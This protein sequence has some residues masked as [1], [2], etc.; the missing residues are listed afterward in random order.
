MVL[1]AT[2][3]IE[4]VLS[5]VEVVLTPTDKLST[6]FQLPLVPADVLFKGIVA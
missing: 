1:G 3:L 2:L 4:L 6:I 5:V